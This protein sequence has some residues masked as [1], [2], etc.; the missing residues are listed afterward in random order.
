LPSIRG[1]PTHKLPGIKRRGRIQ[2]QNTPIC[3]IQNNNCA[4]HPLGKNLMDV[5]LE[6]QIKVEIDILARLR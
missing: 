3:D 2:G 5:P 1:N 4:T 6:G